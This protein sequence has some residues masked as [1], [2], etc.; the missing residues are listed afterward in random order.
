VHV[1]HEAWGPPFV[2]P[3]QE[4]RELADVLL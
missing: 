1:L 3:M 4:Y 2:A